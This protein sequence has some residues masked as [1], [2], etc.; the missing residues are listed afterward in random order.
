MR[1]ILS[2]TPDTLRSSAAG[3]LSVERLSFRYARSS[4]P[5]LDSISFEVGAGET[6]GIVGPSGS[7]KTT[8]LKVIAGYLTPN[9]GSV[10]V[11]GVDI[12]HEALP[13]RGVQLVFQDLKLFDHLTVLENVEFGLHRSAAGSHRILAMPLL[14]RLGLRD[15]RKCRVTELSQGQR[16]RVAIARALMVEPKLLLLDE[17]TAALDNVLKYEVLSL[18]QDL[19]SHLS[20]SVLLVSHDIELMFRMASNAALMKNGKILSVGSLIELYKRP[21]SIESARMLGEINVLDFDKAGQLLC[22][23]PTLLVSAG[24]VRYL[25]FRPE[26]LRVQR[27]LSERGGTVISRHCV[28]TDVVLRIELA[29]DHVV[30][31]IPLGASDSNVSVGD[32]VSLALRPT[33][34]LLFSEGGNLVE[35]RG[36]A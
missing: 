11:D 33:D 36:Y 1:Q 20:A 26:G 28:F 5:L 18:L 7:G 22:L 31:R 35:V 6:F 9:E 30:A 3:L 32:N 16:Q 8:L 27:S 24:N 10:S 17:P 19:R 13:D 15:F 4:R 12:T 34:C 29:G 14:E 21:Q 25:G 23:P 2:T